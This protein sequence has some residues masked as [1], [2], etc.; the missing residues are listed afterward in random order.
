MDTLVQGHSQFFDRLADL[1][2]PKYY[3]GAANAPLQTKYMKHSQK[4]AAKAALKVQKKKNK[5][6]KLDP[7]AAATTT[8][9]QKK[10]KQRV[11][12][13]SDSGS[14]DDDGGAAP[15]PMSTQLA[16]EGGALA[17]QLNISA[18]MLRRRALTLCRNG[19]AVCRALSCMAVD[20][21]APW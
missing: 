20:A 12:Q 10:K 16:A 14:E 3:H 18:G 9:V 6:A 21:A 5:R 17:A 8:E 19:R 11:E 7:D 15:G 2:D 4:V 13:S 1:I